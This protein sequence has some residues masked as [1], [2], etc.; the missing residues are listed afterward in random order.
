[1]TMNNGVQSERLDFCV[2]DKIRF[3]I[4]FVLQYQGT[5]IES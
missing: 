3:A 5:Y 2:K 4:R 1:M